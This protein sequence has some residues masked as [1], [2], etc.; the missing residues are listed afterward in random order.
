MLANPKHLL[1]IYI[2]IVMGYDISKPHRAFP[3][4]IRMAWEKSACGDFVE[5]FE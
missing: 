3:V 2:E 1:G 4:Y 5:V